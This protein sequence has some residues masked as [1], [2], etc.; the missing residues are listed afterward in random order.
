M[1]SRTWVEPWPGVRVAFAR[2]RSPIRHRT[3]PYPPGCLGVMQGVEHDEVVDRAA[4]PRVGAR[5]PGVAQPLGEGLA[6]VPQDVVLGGDDQSRRQPGQF[7][8]TGP[9]WRGG[10]LGALLLALGVLVPVPPHAL[11]G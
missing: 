2:S 5:N 9:Q 6:L 8:E 3:R 1:A 7:F 10:A 11:A 4:E